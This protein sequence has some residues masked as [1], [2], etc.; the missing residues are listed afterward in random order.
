M[1]V[2]LWVI[3]DA[4]LA[5]RTA[6]RLPYV[7]YSTGANKA[8]RT[9]HRALGKPDW[10]AARRAFGLRKRNDKT[11]D[12]ANCFIRRDS[13]I[14]RPNGLFF[15]IFSAMTE[16]IWPAERRMRR[17]E[18][19]R[20]SGAKKP[21]PGALQRIEERFAAGYVRRGRPVRI[22]RDLRRGCKAPRPAAARR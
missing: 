11:Q 1:A 12:G 21:L 17:A 8:T 13:A 19:H 9:A 6:Y 14:S 10:T 3:R 16:K 5:R 4:A 2:R 22:R 20:D 15:H 7:K 18:S